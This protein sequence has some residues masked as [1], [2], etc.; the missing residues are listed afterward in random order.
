MLTINTVPQS[1]YII[2][3]QDV[4]V[5]PMGPEDEKLEEAF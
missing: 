4:T 1:H 5:R 3:D 2:D